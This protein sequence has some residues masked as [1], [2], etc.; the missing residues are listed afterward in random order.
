LWFGADDGKTGT[1]LQRIWR[2]ITEGWQSYWPRRTGR[3][4]LTFLFCPNPAH[5][6]QFFSALRKRC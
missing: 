5:F 1:R 6:A 3:A 4:M 2:A